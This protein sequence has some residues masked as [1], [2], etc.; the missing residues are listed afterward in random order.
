MFC[1]HQKQECLTNFHGDMI[2]LVSTRKEIHRSA[3]KCKNCGKIILNG[4]L[5][6]SC[7]VINYKFI[8]N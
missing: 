5:E 2:N 6:P 7:E 1:K 8:Y 3:W 4:D